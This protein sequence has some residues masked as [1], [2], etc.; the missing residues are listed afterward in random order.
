M[1]LYYFVIGIFL[2]LSLLLCGIIMMQEGKS[3]GLGAG[4]G[5]DTQDSLFG[6]STAEVLKK[7]TAW[8][9]VIFLALCITLSFWTTSIG[10]KR[11][12]TQ[13]AAAERVEGQ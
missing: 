10:K 1:I 11:L 8:M 5:G 13:K 6:V 9:F 3:L 12:N 2:L 7:I 4:F